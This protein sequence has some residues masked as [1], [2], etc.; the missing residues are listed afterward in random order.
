MP[1]LISHRCGG[2]EKEQPDLFPE[3][4]GPLH[5]AVKNAA[6]VIVNEVEEL[7]RKFAHAPNRRRGVGPEQWEDAVEMLLYVIWREDRRTFTR[8][9][10]ELDRSRT[11]RAS[12]EYRS[13]GTDN[14]IR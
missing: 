13:A 5:K 1:P 7:T 2:F 10:E 14:G 12:D 4:Y 6:R 8:L 3:N 9:A 11:H